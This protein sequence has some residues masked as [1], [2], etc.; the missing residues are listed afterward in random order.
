[1]MYSFSCLPFI[2]LLLIG[3]AAA[4]SS[5]PVSIC[6]TPPPDSDCE[7]SLQGFTPCV[8]FLIAPPNKASPTPSTVC[9]LTFLQSLTTTSPRCVCEIVRKACVFGSL[10]DTTRLYSLFPLCGAH[11]VSFAAQWFEE[12][13]RGAA[14]VT[15]TPSA[16]AGD[17][18]VTAAGSQDA[19]SDATPA[20]YL[21]FS[22][23]II[24]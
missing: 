10:I 9:C 16:V 3:S 5:S 23:I 15:L 14:E 12:S 19:G 1:M 2:T 8:P 21:V 7:I 20:I 22:N 24:L 6:N 4:S 13:C 18:T 17:P 11:D